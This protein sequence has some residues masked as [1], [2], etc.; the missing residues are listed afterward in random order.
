M[1]KAAEFEQRVSRIFRLLEES[2][3]EVTWNKLMPDP[4]R[5][6]RSRQIDVEIRRPGCLVHVECRDRGRTQDVAWIE[7][8]IGRRISLKADMVIAVSSSGFT[9]TAIAKAERHGIILR[10]LADVTDDEVMTWGDSSKVSVRFAR[11]LRLEIAI[12][13]QKKEGTILSSESVAR[14]MD[15]QD[16]IGGIMRKATQVCM[17]NEGIEDPV[18][19]EFKG[20][21]FN[22]D[23]VVNDII[24]KPLKIAAKGTV[25]LFDEWHEANGFLEFDRQ[26]SI[27]DLS[28]AHVEKF[29][30][31]GSEI[32]H[33]EDRAIWHVDLSKI[34]AP[35]N[36][37]FEGTIELD[38]GRPKKMSA[39]SVISGPAKIRKPSTAKFMLFGSKP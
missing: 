6:S 35:D 16:W 18:D 5:P 3:T 20:I 1:T 22:D 37:I 13:I 15:Q 9:K 4:D 39:I 23:L 24:V 12:K 2:G 28:E 30:Q 7:D 25:V 32:T 14:V 21:R 11:F 8:L 26:N 34:V 17:D 27:G 29:E 38:F 19:F 10:K 36:C 33:S 31:L